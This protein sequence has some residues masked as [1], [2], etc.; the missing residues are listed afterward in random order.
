MC[1]QR[2]SQAEVVWFCGAWR[3]ATQ[4]SAGRWAGLDWEGVEYQVRSL[5]F[6]QRKKKGSCGKVNKME[7]S[8][9]G[10]VFLEYYTLTALVFNS[11]AGSDLGRK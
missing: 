8:G 5:N 1:E 10:F 4:L 11:V 6:T 9:Y 3:A 7:S 2:Y